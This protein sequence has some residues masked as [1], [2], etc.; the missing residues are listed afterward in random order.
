MEDLCY[1]YPVLRTRR[2]FRLENFKSFLAVGSFGE[3][4]FKKVLYANAKNL[5]LL[6]WCIRTQQIEQIN[7]QLGR[8][9]TK[10][11]IDDSKL[12]WYFNSPF[13]VFQDKDYLYRRSG[14]LDLEQQDKFLRYASQVPPFI[15]AD[16]NAEE[17]IKKYSFE[18]RTKV[19]AAE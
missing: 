17:A 16:L 8:K 4:I 2:D 9:Q 5:D 6:A 14:V 1:V 19:P 18:L 3:G 7:E 12:F 10:Q 13:D 11:E 15:L